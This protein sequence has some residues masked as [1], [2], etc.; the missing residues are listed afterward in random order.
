VKQHLEQLKLAEE[1]GHERLAHQARLHEQE[2][3]M[4]EQQVR[5]PAGVPAMPFLSTIPP[6][7][8]V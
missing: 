2:L 3:S 6:F 1:K 8:S 4:R 5:I 7:P